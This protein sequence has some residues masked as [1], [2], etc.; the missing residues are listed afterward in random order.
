MELKSGDTVKGQISQREAGENCSMDNNTNYILVSV[1]SLAHS[2]TMKCVSGQVQGLY[3]LPIHQTALESY[4][5]K[6]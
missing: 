5:K 2:D 6:T 4:R 3:S 1:Y